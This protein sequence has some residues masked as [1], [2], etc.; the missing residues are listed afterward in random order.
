MSV[1]PGVATASSREKPTPSPP[2]S[3]RRASGYRATAACTSARSDRPSRL[4]MR[5]TPLL[6]TSKAPSTRRS[7]SSPRGVVTRSRTSGSPGSPGS[8]GTAGPVAGSSAT[9]GEQPA[10]ADESDHE[11]CRHAREQQ[12]CRQREGGPH[13]QRDLAAAA[14]LP[15]EPGQ[16]CGRPAEEQGLQHQRRHQRPEPHDGRA[17]EGGEHEGDPG[18]ETQGGVPTQVE[19][20]ATGDQDGG[21]GH[22]GR[23]GD[24]VGPGPRQQPGGTKR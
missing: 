5:N 19:G 2:T 4:S 17:G 15:A 16:R 7:T 21:Q 3:R 10:D 18:A 8:A 24:T 6:I 13:V 20:D 14:V 22:H 11:G 23:P 9:S 12:R 1:S